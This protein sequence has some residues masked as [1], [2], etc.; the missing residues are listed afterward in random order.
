MDY[1]DTKIFILVNNN[2]LTG[3]IVIQEL[4][5]KLVCQIKTLGTTTRYSEAE[6]EYNRMAPFNLYIFQYLQ[7]AL[8]HF[9]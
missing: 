7:Y 3:L 5:E 4:T 2:Y 9:L 6:L 1:I 8:F